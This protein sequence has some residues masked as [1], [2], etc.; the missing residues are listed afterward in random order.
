MP[1]WMLRAHDVGGVDVAVDVGLDHAVHGEAAES[2]DQLRMVADLLRAQDDPVAVVGRCWPCNSATARLRSARTRWPTPP[3]CFPSRAGRACRPGSLRCRR[4]ARSKRR[5][6][7]P[8]STALAILPT[9]DCSGSSDGG[10][11]PRLTSWRR[12]SIRCPAIAARGVVGRANGTL[13]SG[14][15]GLDDG[16]DLLGGQ[17][18]GRARRCGRLGADR[19]RHAMRRQRG[20]VVDVVHALQRRGCQC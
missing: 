7:S 15:V 1:F 2:A 4:S 10:S 16:D 3:S 12:N 18:A 6:A 19:D 20:A 13:R 5:F 17:R 9:P 11:R 14:R 8:A